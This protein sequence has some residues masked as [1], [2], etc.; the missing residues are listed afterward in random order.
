[1][2]DIRENIIY[3]DVEPKGEIGAWKYLL[4]NLTLE[5]INSQFEK[6]INSCL[7]Y[8]TSFERIEACINSLFSIDYK[9]Y[10]FYP[11]FK[12]I[13]TSEHG[14]SNNPYYLFRIRK[15]KEG[16]YF[17]LSDSNSII[18]ESFDFEEIQTLDDIW[19]RP[20]EKAINYQRLS[21]PYNSVL[22]TSLMPSTALLETNI[23]EKQDLFFLIVYKTRRYIIYNDCYSFV[24]YNE[25]TE[26]ENFKRYIIFQFL[27]NEFTR[28]LPETYNSE[29]QY[30]SAASISRKFFITPGVDGIQYPSTRGLGHRN[31]AFWSSSARDCL[32]LVGIRCCAMDKREGHESLHK[33]FA[34]CFWNKD[35]MK[36][37]YVSP[38]SD[39]SKNVFSDPILNILM[40]K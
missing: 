37:E 27:R 39:T 6:Y 36:F 26:T 35:A 32:E 34:D 13:I 8:P 24:Y 19:E 15:I 2:I 40:S 38:L 1:M 29:N 10:K 21:K 4:Q 23:R 17:D 12:S 14:N 25:L 3:T 28:V 9:G 7:L 31:F 18:H 20:P 5:K 33:V 11:H 16:V 30:C 22:Y